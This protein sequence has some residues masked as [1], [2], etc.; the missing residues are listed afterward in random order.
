VLILVKQH[1]DRYRVA[2]RIATGSLIGWL[3]CS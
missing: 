3:G 2:T 1:G